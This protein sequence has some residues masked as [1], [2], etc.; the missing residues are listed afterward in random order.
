MESDSGLFLEQ[1]L[2]FKFP[3]SNNQAEYEA[4]LAGLMTA[5]ELGA[6]HITICSDSQ[7]MISQVNGDYLAKEAIM[8]KYLQRVREI[9][10]NFQKV[11]F[12]HVPRDQNTRA[13][14]V[15]RLASMKRLAAINLSYSQLWPNPVSLLPSPL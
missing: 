11:E 1:S 3:T 7:L 5:K 6:Q 8:Q 15:S 9:A 2:W 14:I 4:C 12:T 13:D 10:L